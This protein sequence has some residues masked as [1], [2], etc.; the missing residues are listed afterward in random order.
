VNI[1]MNPCIL[2]YWAASDGMAFKHLLVL[3]T[4]Q[5]RVA[6]LD[7]IAKVLGQLAKESV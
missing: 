1:P 6:N 4:N 3:R 5:S 7:G 2:V